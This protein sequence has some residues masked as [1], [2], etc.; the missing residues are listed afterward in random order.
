MTAP[1]TAFPLE[2]L[3][4]CGQCSEQMTLED[5]REPRYACRH[6]CSPWLRAG[7]G[8]TMIIGR[9]LDTV[10]T[11]R[12]TATLLEAANE[13]LADETGAQHVLTDRDIGELTNRPDLLI[14]A[15]GSVSQTRCLLGRFIKEIQIDAGRAIV[16]YSI[17]LPADSPLAGM[18]DQ[19]IDL[20][21]DLAA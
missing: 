4:I 20:A 8:D 19:Q 7:A 15:A 13:G 6:G 1:I 11:P 12:N 18:K 14:Q 21:P 2:G 5:D 3:L 10:L 16:R 17:P 9:V